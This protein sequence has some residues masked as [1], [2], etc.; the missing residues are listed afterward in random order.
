M[1]SDA[2]YKRKYRIYGGVTTVA[3]LSTLWLV[4]G[5]VL[6]IVSAFIILFIGIP[7]SIYL[8]EKPRE[9]KK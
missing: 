9:S 7:V 2:E 8:A 1:V 6:P 5:K 4:P 3:F